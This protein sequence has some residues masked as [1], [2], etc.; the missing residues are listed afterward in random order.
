[1]EQLAY[2]LIIPVHN[3]AGYVNTLFESI[4]HRADLEVIV[5]DDRSEPEQAAR[6]RE[7]LD[8]QAFPHSRFLQ[9][10]RG[11]GAGGARNTGMD[12]ARGRWLVF[13]DSDDSFTAE[14]DAAL[15]R[16]AD[17]ACDIVLFR[18]Y[19]AADQ[20]SQD[21]ITYLLPVFDSGDAFAYGLLS[22]HVLW[23]FVRRDLVELGAIRCTESSV[24]NDTWFALSAVSAA[25][26]LRQDPTPIYRHQIRKGSLTQHAHSF[27]ELAARAD[28]QVAAAKLI[29]HAAPKELWR[30]ALPTKDWLL[31]R[32]LAWCGPLGYLRLAA[33]LAGHGLPYSRAARNP[34]LLAWNTLRRA[35]IVARRTGWSG[36]G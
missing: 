6:T 14:F 17:T 23:R 29:R 13:A 3:S 36:H 26:T 11:P 16:W 20:A 35:A 33:R 7:L 15:T 28:I 2:S 31:V 21:A 18:P 34:I 5:V 19:A 1:M 4:P 24:G 22:H 27:G 30:V 9:N 10:L 32:A 12:H 25:T 8:A